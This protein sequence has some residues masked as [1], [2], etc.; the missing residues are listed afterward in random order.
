MAFHWSDSQAATLQPFASH[1]G[2]EI[3]PAK[4]D[5]L[6]D[7]IKPFSRQ[8]GDINGDGVRDGPIY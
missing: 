7:G 2:V 1:D 8:R 5:I 4:Q 3:F 6:G